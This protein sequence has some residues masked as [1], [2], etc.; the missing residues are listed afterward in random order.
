MLDLDT[1]PLNRMR[2]IFHLELLDPDE[3]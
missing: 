2:T 3:D 1:A